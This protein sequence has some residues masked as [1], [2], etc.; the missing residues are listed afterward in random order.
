M[1]PKSL[2]ST[3]KVT[4]KDAFDSKG[5]LNNQ[6]QVVELR[7]LKVQSLSLQVHV[8]QLSIYWPVMTLMSG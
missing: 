7:H 3:S 2:G 1:D 8:T 6:N 5:K 4:N